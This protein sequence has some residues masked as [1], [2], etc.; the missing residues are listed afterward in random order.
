M[1]K[2]FI[3]CAKE[4]KEKKAD[5]RALNCFNSLTIFEEVQRVH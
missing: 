1:I 5:K 4:S 2:G 3:S